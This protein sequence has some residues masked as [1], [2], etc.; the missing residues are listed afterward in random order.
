ML[1]ARTKGPLWAESW[2]WER[3]AQRLPPPESGG[4]R[5]CWVAG[6]LGPARSATKCPRGLPGNGSPQSP[7]FWATQTS[8]ST[9]PWPQGHVLSSLSS[10]A[11]EAPTLRCPPFEQTPHLLEPQVRNSGPWPAV[12]GP[13]PLDQSSLPCALLDL[14]GIPSSPCPTLPVAQTTYWLLS[15]HWGWEPPT[16]CLEGTWA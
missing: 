11:G 9:Q 16:P 15:H 14:K 10:P 8:P 13:G 12:D 4:L 1:A 7:V 3:Q 2:R 6:H 5:R